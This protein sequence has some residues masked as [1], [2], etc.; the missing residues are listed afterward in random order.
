MPFR[1]LLD[2]EEIASV[3]EQVTRLSVMTS[4]GVGAEV[5]IADE[6]AVDIQLTRVVPGGVRRLDE[7][8]REQIERDRERA[9]EGEPVGAP[10]TNAPRELN[11]NQFGEKNNPPPDVDLSQGLESDDSDTLTARVN[12]FSSGGDAQKAIDDNPPGTGTS[13]PLE[14]DTSVDT[15]VDADTSTGIGSD[16]DDFDLSPTSSTSK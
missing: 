6:G 10:P 4:R 2:G 15:S 8:E 5:G 1:I 7:L 11:T 14:D 13:T 9:A 16:A 12:A 3:D